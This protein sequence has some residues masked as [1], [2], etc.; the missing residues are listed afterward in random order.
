MVPDNFIHTVCCA[1]ENLYSP[2]EKPGG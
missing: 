2:S 1:N